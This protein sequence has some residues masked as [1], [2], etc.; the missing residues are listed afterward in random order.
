MNTKET[1]Q[2]PGFILESHNSSTIETT[3]FVPNEQELFVS[4]KNGA[5]YIYNDFT[6]SDYDEFMA[7]ESKGVHL[8]RV[9]KRNFEFTKLED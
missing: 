7:A 4:F 8:G 3:K 5:T 1:T 9:I 2:I 6:Q